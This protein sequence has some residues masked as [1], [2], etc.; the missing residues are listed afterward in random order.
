MGCAILCVE[1][2]WVTGIL[3]PL[4][5]SVGFG[6]I[7]D[8]RIFMRHRKFIPPVRKIPFTQAGFDKLK[9][10]LSSLQSQRPEAVATLAQARAMGD[11]SE[12]GMYK[13]A[14]ARLSSI[15]HRI[16]RLKLL[17]KQAEIAT[18]MGKDAVQIGSLVTIS[19]GEKH[20]T[21]TIVGGYESDPSSAKISHISPLGRA[22][23]K[24][25]EGESVTVHA[26]AGEV[27]YTIEK[28]A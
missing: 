6:G 15:D 22:L 5:R 26:P 25:S 24:K 4:L 28:I 11:L 12:N 19:S 21:V 20:Q 14:R 9:E 13:A 23:M 17:L 2:D 1:R 8:N 18:P 27:E 7:Y 10:E 16:D 3:P